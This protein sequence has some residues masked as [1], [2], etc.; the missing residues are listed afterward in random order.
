M[1]NNFQK[2]GVQL[3]ERHKDNFTFYLLFP[4]GGGNFSFHHRVHNSSGVYPPSYR[5][6]IRGSLPGCKAA[7]AWSSPLSS[8]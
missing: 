7:G 1:Q 5:I 8:I 2:R 6:G 3:K 4:A